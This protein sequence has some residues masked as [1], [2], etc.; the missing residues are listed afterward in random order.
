M[1]LLR[2]RHFYFANAFEVEAFRAKAA[3]PPK[4]VL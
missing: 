3:Q 4:D 1:A 2:G